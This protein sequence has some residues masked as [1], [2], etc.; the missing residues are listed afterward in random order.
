MRLCLSGLRSFGARQGNAES[1]YSRLAIRERSKFEREENV[2]E[3]RA[4]AQNPSSPYYMESRP[5]LAVVTL[6]V[7]IR[8]QS[9]KVGTIN[10]VPSLKAALQNVAA[11]AMTD[12]GDNVLACEVLWTPQNPSDVLTKR[13]LITDYPELIDI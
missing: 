11:D 12:E 13:D 3:R 8:G 1:E 5:T 4:T 9:T 10:S 2:M 7:A 6:C